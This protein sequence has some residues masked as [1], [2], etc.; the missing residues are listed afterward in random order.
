LDNSVKEKIEHEI[1]RIDKLISDA[2]PLLNLYKVKEPDFVEVTATAQILHSFYNL[3]WYEMEPLV[4]NLKEIW[5]IIKT[6]FRL[7]VENN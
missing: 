7:F 3:E 1:H 4:K 2:T 5:G 6:D